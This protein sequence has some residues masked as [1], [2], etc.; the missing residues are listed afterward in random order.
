MLKVE[1]AG[2]KIVLGIQIVAE[3]RSMNVHV[4]PHIYQ[5]TFSTFPILGIRPGLP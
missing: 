5:T 1:I 4:C 2:D 3:L